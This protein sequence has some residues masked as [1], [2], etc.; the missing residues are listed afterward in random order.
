MTSQDYSPTLVGRVPAASIEEAAARISNLTNG[1]LEPLIGTV[2]SDM[3]QFRRSMNEAG[4]T[5]GYIKKKESANGVSR[6]F[7]AQSTCKD[8]SQWESTLWEH[9][10][11]SSIV[12]LIL[13]I[14]T[15]KANAPEIDEFQ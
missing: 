7:M 5:T 9:G 1:S 11:D 10:K 2:Y 4:F 15:K 3:E 12:T 8:G 6:I 13:T 14:Q